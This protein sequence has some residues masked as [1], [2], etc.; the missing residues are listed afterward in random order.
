MYFPE[1]QITTN[2]Y[3]PGGEYMVISSGLEYI[4]YYWKTSTGRYFTGNTPQTPNSLEL[5]TFLLNE[6]SGNINQSSPFYLTFYPSEEAEFG[7]NGI[8]N[9]TQYIIRPI[10]SVYLEAKNISINSQRLLPTYYPNIP[11]NEDYKIGEYR[12][13]FCKKVNEIN[14][15]EINK[16]YYDKLVA[17]DQTVAFEYYIPFNV[18]WLLTGDQKQVYKVNKNIVELTI[19]RKKLPMFNKYLREDYTKYYKNTA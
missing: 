13:Y 17:N 9:N 18:P 6:L 3:T 15:T 14:Y 5:K 2:L 12:R 8:S 7:D 4:G 16:S 10:P 11:T 1:S 19:Q